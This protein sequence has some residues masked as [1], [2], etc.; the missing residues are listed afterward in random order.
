MSGQI[1]EC[2]VKLIDDSL[3]AGEAE[4]VEISVHRN[5]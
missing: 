1:S 3:E 4:E 2:L 5:E